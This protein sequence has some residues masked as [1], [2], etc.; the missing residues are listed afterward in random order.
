M[1]ELKLRMKIEE[2]LLFERILI[3]VVVTDC[4]YKSSV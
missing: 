2:V 1:A 4:E 3:C